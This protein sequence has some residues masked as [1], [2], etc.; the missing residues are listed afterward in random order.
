MTGS[1]KL[2]VVGAGL[3]GKRHAAAM[4]NAGSVELV[5]IVDPSS[6]G[7]AFAQDIGA[8]W[9]PS[10]SDM[11]AMSV[12]DGIVVATP[13]QA[14]VENGVECIAARCPMLIEKPIAT[15][16]A[17]AAKIVDAGRLA[18]VPILV[19]HHRRHNPLVRNARA[20]L[21]QGGL[22]R[23]VMVHGTCWLSKPDGYFDAAWRKKSGAGPVL[24]NAIHDVD[25][26]RHLCGEIECVQSLASNAVRGGPTEDSAVVL[27]KFRSGTLG[28][29]SISDTVAAPWSWELTAAENTAYPATAQSCYLIGGTKGSLSIPDNRLWNHTANGHWM[30]PMQTTSF[31]GETGDPLVTQL[32]HFAAVIRGEEEPIVSGEEGLKSLAV[33]EAILRSAASG[34][35]V[36]IHA[37]TV[38]ADQITPN[39][40][41]AARS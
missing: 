17:E 20:I 19:G 15:S 12:P 41:P 21:D 26:L 24:V 4:T 13:N 33:I 14:H 9:F 39:S 10:L 35:Q 23:V 7:R 30:T 1:L 31:P 36:Q 29:I 37:C 38:G 5:T 27:L 34:E 25:L 16:V 11:F 32:E 3:I 22:G 18:E 28:T 8:A 6:A 2:A 40:T